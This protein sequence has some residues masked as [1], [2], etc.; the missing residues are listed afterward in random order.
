MQTI[1]QKIFKILHT[2]TYE[3]LVVLILAL[4]LISFAVESDQSY[5][6]K[7][8]YHYAIIFDKIFLYLILIELILKVFSSP[9]PFYKNKWL[10]FDF[11]LISVCFIPN[12]QH[13]A[14]LRSLRVLRVL[15]MVEYVKE[16][17]KIIVGITT[18]IPQIFSTITFLFF[19]LLTYSVMTLK[20]YGTSIP[21]YYGTLQQSLITNFGLINGDSVISVMKRTQKHSFFSLF[22]NMIYIVVIGLTVLSLFT[23]FVV[24]S[25]QK[26]TKETDQEELNTL[27]LLLELNRKIERME[28]QLNKYKNFEE[29]P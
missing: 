29:K 26:V 18:S 2:S 11:I 20:V 6:S 3:Y 17:K 16:F 8:A 13:F 7:V 28:K 25:I 22:L 5:V 27:R 21:E 10:L 9:E 4:N 15:I 23:G 12:Y 24:N 14:F 19:I 1:K